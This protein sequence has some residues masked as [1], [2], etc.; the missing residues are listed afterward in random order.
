[1]NILIGVDL[2]FGVIDDVAVLLN[3]I[4]KTRIPFKYENAGELE[5]KVST[6]MADK[7]MSDIVYVTNY[8]E[9]FDLYF[10][11]DPTHGI[12]TYIGMHLDVFGFEPLES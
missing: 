8:R 7:P 6:I 11:Y 1:M 12:L 2:G 10:N 9:G 4:K 3:D 5:S